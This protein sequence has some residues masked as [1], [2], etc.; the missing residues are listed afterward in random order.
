MQSPTYAY[1]NSYDNK[2]LH[3]DMYR[4]E[5]FAEVVEKGVLNQISEFDFIVIE[6]PKWIDQL[7]L[8]EYLEL[9]IDKISAGE[10]RVKT[11][12]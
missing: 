5:N 3:I 11:L 12:V 6:W 7:D 9:Q 10:R 1:L 4:F 8:G 2:L